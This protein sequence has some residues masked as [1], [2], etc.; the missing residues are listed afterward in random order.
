M[1]IARPVLL[2]AARIEALALPQL[3]RRNPVTEVI[4]ELDRIGFDVGK[5]HVSVLGGIVVLIVVIGVIAAARIGIRLACM[6]LA[7][8]TPFDPTQ[9]VLS[10][11]LVSIA[12]WGIAIMIG[13]DILKID[14]T[15]L[16]VF[17]GAFGL[18]IGFG[19]QKTFGNLI[20]GI[21][22]LTDRSIKPG[23]VIAVGSG[24][25]AT[26]GQVMRIGIRAVS[27]TTRDKIEYLIPNEYLMTS[28]VENWSFS[29]RD[30]RVKVPVGVA[31][32]T[33][34]VFA[35]KLMLEAASN[36][37]RVLDS[38]KPTVWLHE[39]G[40]SSIDFTIMCWINDPED[41]VGNVRSDVLKTVWRLFRD[42][43]VEIPF[44]QRD[45]RVKEW[46]K[47]EQAAEE[48]KS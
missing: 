29:S 34:I 13:I 1:S 8:F 26:V 37:K 44:P 32:D 5:T 14:L 23:D 2:T 47:P 25:D 4:G 46:S 15:A 30:V 43:G 33:D 24:K 28:I 18:A 39:F 40:D 42:N 3:S 16:T 9:R 38:P 21:I 35:E 20:A 17:S 41:G 12:I 48:A 45:I 36:C 11:K 6:S 22:L 10:E 7:R 19:L 31:Y 27:V